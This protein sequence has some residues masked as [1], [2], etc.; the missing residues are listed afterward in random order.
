MRSEVCAYDQL[1]RVFW[2]RRRLARQGGHGKSIARRSGAGQED[3]IVL[4]RRILV[5]AI[6]SAPF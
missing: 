4:T 2:H 1:L 6:G 5:G 3:T